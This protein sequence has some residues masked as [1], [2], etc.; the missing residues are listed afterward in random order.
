VMVDPNPIIKRL[1]KNLNWQRK[2]NKLSKCIKN[3][4]NEFEQT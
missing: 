2:T 4:L 3:L 1:N